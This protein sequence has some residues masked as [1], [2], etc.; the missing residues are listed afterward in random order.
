MCNPF[1]DYISI[2]RLRFVKVNNI[3]TNISIGYNNINYSRNLLFWLVPTSS[4]HV[5][6][7]SPVSS[8]FVYF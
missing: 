7:L 4:Q 1:Y 3:D 2:V 8:F 5:L 6:I